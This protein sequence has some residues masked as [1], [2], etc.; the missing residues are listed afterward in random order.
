MCQTSVMKE[1]VLKY[2]LVSTPI[3]AR[4][5]TNVMNVFVFYFITN[6]FTMVLYNSPVIFSTKLFTHIYKYKFI[7]NIT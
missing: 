3:F 5:I 6:L 7:S 4:S 1:K 2:I